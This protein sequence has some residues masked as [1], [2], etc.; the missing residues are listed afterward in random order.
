M[1][2]IAGRFS[3]G[4]VQCAEPVFGQ[5]GFPRQLVAAPGQAESLLLAEKYQGVEGAVVHFQVGED[6]EERLRGGPAA[7]GQDYSREMRMS[8]GMAGAG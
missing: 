5:E 4:I 8:A 7:V 6:V 1:Y 3:P 2:R